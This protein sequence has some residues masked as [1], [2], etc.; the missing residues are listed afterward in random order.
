MQ[1]EPLQAVRPTPRRSRAVDGIARDGVP[2]GSQ[3]DPDLVGPAGDEVDLEERPAPEALAD[4]VAGDGWPPVR[5]DGHP[6]P[7][8]RIAPDRRLDPAGGRLHATLDQGEVRLL[9]PP[10]LE[11]R[12]EAGLGHV[13]LGHH[14]EPGGVAV[15]AM[16]DPRPG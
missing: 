3:V 9:A 6:G 4:P 1:E 7:L 13:R 2:E 5:D 8:A 15:E 10:R 12:H 16:H 14:D 11:L